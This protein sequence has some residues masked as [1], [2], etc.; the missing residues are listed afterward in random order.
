MEASIDALAATYAG[1]ACHYQRFSYHQSRASTAPLLLRRHFQCRLDDYIDDVG[2]NHNNTLA[3]GSNR[4]KCLR[5]EFTNGGVGPA[6]TGITLD[7]RNDTLLCVLLSV[8]YRDSYVEDCVLECY[9]EVNESTKFIDLHTSR[10]RNDNA[11]EDEEGACGK[12]NSNG[13]VLLMIYVPHNSKAKR[14]VGAIDRVSLIRQV[15]MA[16]SSVAGDNRSSGGSGGSDMYGG[17]QAA[18]IE[19]FAAR[20]KRPCMR[21]HN[22]AG[23]A[24]TA[25][26]ATSPP[27]LSSSAIMPSPPTKKPCVHPSPS[28]QSMSTISSTHTTMSTVSSVSIRPSHQQYNHLS[29]RNQ[30]HQLQRECMEV[31]IARGLLQPA[32]AL[33]KWSKYTLEKLTSLSLVHSS[34]SGFGGAFTGACVGGAKDGSS[35][36]KGN[37]ADPKSSTINVKLL[38]SWQRGTSEPGSINN[39]GRPM[40]DFKRPRAEGGGGTEANPYYGFTG[41]YFHFLFP[42]PQQPAAANAATALQSMVEFNTTMKCPWCDF[43][44]IRTDDTSADG[45]DIG[46]STAA[47]RLFKRAASLLL[48]HLQTFHYH[49]TYEAIIDHLR[50][51]HV[52]VQQTSAEAAT[53][54]DPAGGLS[55][56]RLRRSDKVF[57][58]MRDRTA[59]RSL[60]DVP[61]AHLTPAL[62]TISGSD[63]RDGSQDGHHNNMH[64]ISDA[65]TLQGNISDLLFSRQYYNPRTGQPL[66]REELGT[67]SEDDFIHYNRVSRLP[68]GSDQPQTGSKEN[69]AGAAS[70]AAAAAEMNAADSSKPLA[71]QLFD[72]LSK[73]A[74]LLDEFSDVSFEEK[75]FMKLWNRHVND[76]Q[77]HQ[78]HLGMKSAYPQVAPNMYMSDCY[79]LLVFESFV[80]KYAKAIVSL[81]LRHNLLLHLMVAYD[82]GLL[83][84]DEILK[85]VAV[86][87][88]CKAAVDN[89]MA[90]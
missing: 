6:N 82:F 65:G 89:E 81:N 9:H 51:L 77:A 35:G 31:R 22:T 58:Y 14:G 7:N 24:T 85:C 88:R 21:A 25:N 59:R 26:T 11:N 1:L 55:K 42:A 90:N 45:H 30:R 13:Y 84:S 41:C 48:I 46:S 57:S 18:M 56:S 29:P 69:L 60:L 68:I 34:S 79:A 4:G 17:V 10:S 54:I 61:I 70:S 64:D 83:R 73:S 37:A 53:V 28:T 39:N 74:K 12:N 16:Y 2:G 5:L 27:S 23:G 66:R 44:P 32:F 67:A 8:R 87:D 40:H 50:C 75:T 72:P 63:S 49:C 78:G 86:V 52:V 36:K 20:S 33:S 38:A 62:H 3:N 71:F 15:L 76:H 43:C 19:L 80:M 47:T